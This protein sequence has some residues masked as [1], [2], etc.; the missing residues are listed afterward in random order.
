MKLPILLGA[1][2]LFWG[3]QTGLWLLAI[4]MALLLEG[5]HLIQ[6]R[7]DFSARN[8]RRIFNLCL[9][10]A[11][12]ALAYILINQRSP[13]FIYALLQWLPVAGWPLLAAQAYSIGDRVNLSALFA[14]PSQAGSKLCSLDL[15]LPYFAICLLS[16]SAAKSGGIGFYLGMVGLVAWALWSGRSRRHSPILWLS[17]LLIA[18]GIGFV[19]HLGLHQLHVT[20]EQRS[21]AWLSQ[22]TSQAV[23]PLQT[24]TRIGDI[25]Q[26]KLSNG[27]VFRVAASDRQQFPL[28]LRQT[29]YNKYQSPTWV[30]LQSQ[31]APIQPDPNG[32]TWQLG[33][34]ATNPAVI[35]I[36][37]ENRQGFLTLPDGTFQVNSLPVAKLEKNQYGTVKVEGEPGAI[38]YDVLFKQGRSFDRP[39]TEADLQVPEAE[40]PA[41]AQTLQ[42]LSL[43]GQLSPAILNRVSSFFQ[44]EF[45]YSLNLTGTTDRATPIANFLLKS[46]TGH[47]E[48]FAAANTLLLRQAGIPA[49]YAVGY[50][51]HEFSPLE[52]QYIVRGRHAHAW[53]MVYLNNTWQSFDTTPADWVSFED[54]TAPPWQIVAD[55]WSFL[56]FKL[57]TGLSQFGNKQVFEVVGWAIAPLLLFLL[58]QFSRR[59][60]GRRLAVK[61]ISAAAIAQPAK[62]G[63]DSE[64]YLIEQTLSKTGL[65]RHASE[66]LT[67]WMQR[68]QAELPKA[69]LDHLRTILEL[70]Y[71]Y[72]F[73][74]N[75]ME[76]SDRAKLT[77]LCHQWLEDFQIIQSPPILGDLG[78]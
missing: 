35:K 3:W 61:T 78:G 51:V 47:C 69:Q 14:N 49:R 16:A 60:R 8:F 23:N 54:A 58:W 32:T 76:V 12:L 55:G 29:T 52:G 39:P 45:K 25:G 40:K 67:V 5:Q 62:T 2:L 33:E 64:L 19:G 34:E 74:P 27:I 66:S 13:Y 44:R 22:F 7:W 1:M 24:N 63:I 68:L 15:N 17:T 11:V 65:H 21:V 48:Y 75:G 28:L 77:S 41:I 71:R 56:V 30:A 9:L 70:H 59:K 42:Q 31:F 72:R 37:T 43:E 73:D 57:S 6:W 26:V 10:I 20:M 50:S 46:R 4:P 53:T 36:S 18:G 38:A